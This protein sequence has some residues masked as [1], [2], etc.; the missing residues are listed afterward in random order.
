MK[1]KIKLYLHDDSYS[2]ALYIKAKLENEWFYWHE[3]SV[4]NDYFFDEKN[5]KYKTKEKFYSDVII[6]L[7]DEEKI[8][9]EGK[10]FVKRILKEKLEIAKSKSNE[11]EVKK[12]LS[13]LKTIEIEV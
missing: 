10:R 11:A 5:L 3:T 6:F 9:E 4:V 8:K 7:K 12:L 1:A 2:R 13:K